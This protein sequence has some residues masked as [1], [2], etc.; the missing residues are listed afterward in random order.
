MPD[1]GPTAVLAVVP[2]LLYLAVLR[3]ID[4]YEPEPWTF[5]LAAVGLGAL[6]APVLSMA[7]LAALGY[8]AS[9]PGEAALTGPVP[10]IVEQVVKGVLLLLLI[11]AIRDTFDD[12]VDGIVYGAALGAGFAMTQS[13]LLLA[14]PN[15]LGLGTVGVLI[16][17]LNQAFYSAVVGGI[18]GLAASLP[19]RDQYWIVVALG[20][21]TAAFLDALHDSVPFMIARLAHRPDAALSL[22]T[23]GIAFAVNVGG[24]VTLAVVVVGA[25]RRERRIV[26]VE[27]HDEAENGVIPDDEIATLVSQRQRLEAQRQAWGRGGLP[28]VR[29]LRRLHDLEAALAFHKWRVRRRPNAGA[30]AEADA[31]RARIRDLRGQLEGRE[32]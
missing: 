8:P 29:G 13:F 7:V 25:W 27:L 15:Q 22:L 3:A 6:A 16:A 2:A 18:V 9:L 32:A 4:R 19:R 1:L 28:A 21:A 5:I 14:A 23:R 17:G 11:H 30:D 24:L 20:I 10:A 12:V 31:M 26:A